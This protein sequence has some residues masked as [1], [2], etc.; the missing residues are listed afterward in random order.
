M[1]VYACPHKSCTVVCPVDFE[2]THTTWLCMHINSHKEHKKCLRENGRDCDEC[3]RL[4]DSGEW[5]KQYGYDREECS[6]LGC[7]FYSRI[8]SA[9]QRRQ[10]LHRHQHAL[11]IHLNHV[12][13][14]RKSCDHCQLMFELGIWTD[15]MLEKA[16]QSKYR[17]R[18]ASKETSNFAEPEDL[19]LEDEMI[20]IP[21]PSTVNTQ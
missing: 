21:I 13:T 5:T 10:A 17:P 6:H 15:D 8:P 9:G 2:L 16:K 11:P 1:E 20:C 19:F 18:L 3:K 7:K 4:L 14:C 12:L